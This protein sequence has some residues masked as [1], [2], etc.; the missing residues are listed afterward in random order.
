MS[1]RLF[2]AKQ[3]ILA[4]DFNALRNTM[5]KILFEQFLGKSIPRLPA[6]IANSMTPTEV[7]NTVV[8]ESGIAFQRILQSDGS[9]EV[10]LIN[11]EADETV[12]FNLPSGNDERYD[13]VECRSA[14]VDETT[15][16]RRFKE[17]VNIED[18]S[19][20]IS[21]KWSAEVQVQRG[22][23]SNNYS[24]SIGWVPIALVKLNSTGIVEITDVRNFYN[25]FDP[26]FFTVY[27][28][29]N[30]NFSRKY[31]GVN[32]I[33]VP[34][35]FSDLISKIDQINVRRV[36]KGEYGQIS[37]TNTYASN[38][39]LN[40]PVGSSTGLSN[41]NQT[42]NGDVSNLVQLIRG[43]EPA[44]YRFRKENVKWSQGNYGEQDVWGIS[45]GL[46]RP[47]SRRVTIN[48]I[49]NR[50]IGTGS[51]DILD[52]I[53]SL[54]FDA[55]PNSGI[56]IVLST[57]NVPSISNSIVWNIPK[58][59]LRRESDNLVLESVRNG[60]PGTGISPIFKSS[61]ITTSHNYFRVTTVN[62][63]ISISG[64]PRYLGNNIPLNISGFHQLRSIS[65]DPRLKRLV[66]VLRNT[67]GGATE[68]P[69]NGNVFDRLIIKK[70]SETRLIKDI[71]DLSI[72]LN[73]IEATY[74]YN[75]NQLDTLIKDTD[76]TFSDFR[77]EFEDYNTR[78]EEIWRTS[79]LRRNIDF[80]L[81]EEGPRTYVRLVGTYP[82]NIDDELIFSHV[83]PQSLINQQTGT[84]ESLTIEQE[85]HRL[86]ELVNQLA[87][88]TGTPTTLLWNL[89][90][91]G[92]RTRDKPTIQGRVDTSISAGSY[93]RKQTSN[94]KT[95]G[96]LINVTAGATSG[97]YFMWVAIETARVNNIIFDDDEP[98]WYRYKTMDIGDI[99]YTIFVR[100]TSLRNG[101]EKQFLI[102]NYD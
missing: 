73:G 83:I 52:D 58:N 11:L 9:T 40:R 56:Y 60:F 14:I 85:I 61:D 4:K 63:I 23:S 38:F 77:I 30:I 41:S 98:S 91:V 47:P 92:T 90:A 6:F 81:V 31:D 54:D 95:A 49:V 101:Q 37:V 75:L 25:I 45:I 53:S 5:E 66:F 17:G 32:L 36:F 7:G 21:N 20:L 42:F 33:E 86:S 97:S 94:L 62:P 68:F 57:S 70:G 74:T 80:S 2:K 44:S 78:G 35:T 99:N 13:L 79:L 26:D 8:V 76:T 69:G 18:R 22:V 28:R 84:P 50:D 1:R 93:N 82:F 10:R 55:I 12:N 29:S 43:T 65:Y 67:S 27:G 3:E 39:G 16:N 64:E 24:A 46:I 96:A 102:K 88:R 51:N 19:T 34:F 89:T 15:E 48:N 72:S 71:S 100:Q 59:L 87:S